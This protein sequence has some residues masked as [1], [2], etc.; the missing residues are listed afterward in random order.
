MTDLNAIFAEI[1]QFNEAQYMQPGEFT[2]QQ[3]AEAMG[4]SEQMASTE[5]DRAV[6]AGLVE[7]IGKRIGPGGKWIRAYRWKNDA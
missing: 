7:D 5:I 1:R 2:R 3:Y 4:L 6:E